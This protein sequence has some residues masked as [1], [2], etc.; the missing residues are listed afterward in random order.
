MNLPVFSRFQQVS[1]A[2]A[3]I[4]PAE[5]AVFA[6]GGIAAATELIN[7]D[8]L[9]LWMSWSVTR[10]RTSSADQCEV[11]VANLSPT[12]RAAL[13]Q[14]WRSADAAG[15]PF[16]MA[17]YLGWDGL[18]TLAFTGQVYELIP[19][20]REGE[21]VLTIIRM[22]DGFKRVDKNAA[23]PTVHT[24]AAGQGAVIWGLLVYCFAQLGLTVDPSQQPIVE[25]AVVQTPLPTSGQIS[26][27][28][29][30]ADV[31]DGLVA[32]I[33]LEWK[34]IDGVAVFMRQGITASA[35]G[36]TAI[37]FD[38]LHGLLDWEETEAGGI[39]VEALAQ[40]HVRPGDQ[41]VVI[42]SFAVPLSPGY[43]VEQD[44]LSGSIDSTSTMVVEGRPTVPL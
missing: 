34:V 5:Q 28:G 18:L 19:D 39:R 4:N 23:A 21:D 6:A 32:S 29:E 13:F 2:L 8:G 24:Y 41:F 12:T 10:T 27:E 44:Q 22:G 33:G 17:L 40:P 43:R 1:A 26:L 3:G 9:G 42:D 11:Q 35:Q 37:V 16:P 14:A 30:V 15:L 36:A 7:L 38:A 25:A 31:L 20:R